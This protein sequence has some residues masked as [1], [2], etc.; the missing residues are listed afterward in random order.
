MWLAALLLVPVAFALNWLELSPVLVFAAGAVAI[1]PLA[2]WIRRATEQMAEAFGS[3][4]GGLLN[5][6]FGNLAEM[7]L[8]IFVLL[9]GHPDVVKGQITGSIL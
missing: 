9:D 7:L 2:E 1:V 8:A 3:A 4:I 5:V 6:T